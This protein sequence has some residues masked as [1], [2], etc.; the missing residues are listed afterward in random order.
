LVDVQAGLAGPP[1][2]DGAP[3]A[4]R[5]QHFVVFL[6]CQTEPSIQMS[7]SRERFYIR[8]FASLPPVFIQTLSIPLLPFLDAG[9]L[10]CRICQ[11]AVMLRRQVAGLTATPVTVPHASSLVEIRNRLGRAADFASFQIGHSPPFC[12]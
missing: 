2:A 3:A 10:S 6:K 9:D 8:E 7:G 1:A 12:T 11:V 5:D 4:L